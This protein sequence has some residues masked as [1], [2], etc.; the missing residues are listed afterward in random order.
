MP[1]S[2]GTV[3]AAAGR[4]KVLVA[5]DFGTTFTSVAY[6]HT[7]EAAGP[8]LLMSWGEGGDN[9][10]G[11]VPTVLRYDNGEMSGPYVWGYRAQRWAQQ[12]ERIH[13]WFKLGLCDD[14]EERRARES[15]LA[16]LYDS[17]TAKPPVKGEDCEKLV[18]DY[19]VGIK[20][21][22]DK[23]LGADEQVA[24]MERLYIITVPALWDYSEQE[25]TRTCAER[26]DMGKGSEITLIPESEA[27]GIWAIKNMPS[28]EEGDAFVVCDAGGGTVDLTSFRVKSLSKNR[29]QCELVGAGAGSGGLCGSIF[30]N[31]IFE[32]YLEEKLQDYPS[33]D[34]DFMID[35]LGAFE[36]RIKPNFSGRNRDAHF[37]RIQGLKPSP[38]HG[39]KKNFLEL[40]DDELRVNVF[41]I[42]IN[43][44]RV[45]VRDQI[46]HTEG[47]VKE[48][49]LAG[50]FG[51][52]PYLK[53]RLQNLDCVVRQGIK[54]SEFEDSATAIVKGAV[55]ASLYGLER[56]TVAFDGAFNFMSTRRVG[57]VSRKAGRHYGTWGY[58]DYKDGD[59]IEK[60]YGALDD[61]LAVSRKANMMRRERRDD[62]VK[63]AR[64]HWFAKMNDDIP[65]GEPQYYPYEKIAKVIPGKKAHEVCLIDIPIF[66]C[67][68]RNPPEYRND[69]NAWKITDFSLDLQGLTIPTIPHN[70]GRTRFYKANFEIEMILEAT[71]L[72]FCGVYGRN[73]P[74]ERRCPAK[75]VSF[76]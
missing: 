26:A 1:Q 8:H 56:A 64:M 68:K 76:K 29:R 28:I 49:V 25:K 72:T 20:Q 62:G 57:V 17:K 3:S 71:S 46:K 37:I 21:A 44:I 14:F 63:V 19:L 39:I 67:E 27:A 73:T 54:V 60:K 41:D 52:N 70:G 6:A 11:Q 75:K 53:R 22:V 38:R 23:K 74:D 2:S 58:D 48:V 45:L 36:T 51:R 16:K 47:S 50:G 43:K 9:T 15:E 61:G 31:R 4:G 69:P 30:L 18:R 55:T 12:S 32:K 42:V 10:E 34:P 35:A 59:P 13:E 33:W 65:N 40:T 66:V 24:A 5:V 7:A